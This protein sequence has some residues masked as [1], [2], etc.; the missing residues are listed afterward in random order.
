MLSA[1]F[2]PR[3]LSNDRSCAV[4]RSSNREYDATV[5]D[6]APGA[7][8][9]VERHGEQVVPNPGGSALIQARRIRTFPAGDAEQRQ[10]LP[11]RGRQETFV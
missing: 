8:A 10:P 4:R 7:Q 9:A 2:A 3:L 11:W 1:V 6:D 5:R